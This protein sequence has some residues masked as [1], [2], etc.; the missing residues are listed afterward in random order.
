[1]SN[2]KTTPIHWDIRDTAETKQDAVAA[3]ADFVSSSSGIRMLCAAPNSPGARPH[4]LAAKAYAEKWEIP[5]SLSFLKSALSSMDHKRWNGET[6]EPAPRADDFI[7][8][9]A[10]WLA[11]RE[12]RD[13]A[14]EHV[15]MSSAETSD[16]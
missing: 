1:M 13:A 8:P 10:Y 7:D 3:L 5:F 4:L 9:R 16:C 2:K 12:W 6:K 11:F 15:W 14:E